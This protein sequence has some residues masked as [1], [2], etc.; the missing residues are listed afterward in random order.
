MIRNRLHIIFA[1]VFA[2]A[3]SV[4]CAHREQLEPEPGSSSTDPYKGMVTFAVGSTSSVVPQTKSALEC[5]PSKV[6][7]GVHQ[8]DSLFIVPSVTDNNDPLPVSEDPQVKGSMVTSSS[9][10][11]F[12]VTATLENGIKY[13]EWMRLSSSDKVTVNGQDVFTTDYYWPKMSMDFFASNYAVFDGTTGFDSMTEVDANPN[14][15]TKSGSAAESCIHFGYDDQGNAMGEFDY[16]LPLTSETNR[17]DAA[18][19]PDYVF[20]IAEDR[21]ENDGVVPLNFAHCFSAVTLNIG[22]KFLNSENRTLKE[23]RINNVKSSGHCSFVR[24]GESIEFTWNTSESELGS[25]VQT[26]DAQIPDG[27]VIN[28]GD[29]TFMLIPHVLSPD[30]QIE[31]VF[32]LHSGELSIDGEYSHSHDWIVTASLSELSS[33]WLPG[34]KYSYT[35]TGEEI[36]CVDVKDEF[37]STEPMVKGNL[38]ITNTGSVPIYVR[39]YIVGWWENSEGIVV[40]PW[41]QNDGQ[42]SGAAWEKPTSNWTISQTD[43]FMY[44]KEPVMPGQ[45]TE[46]L[47]DTY[48]LTS[49][50][51]STDAKLIL[52]VLTQAV[53]HYQVE[54]A[55]PHA[56]TSVGI[57]GFNV[58]NTESYW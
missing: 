20:A 45:E 7:I 2:V 14:W 24:R 36:V 47:F 22:T 50:A 4:S 39:A 40:A 56:T 37:I 16:E 26:I 33:E 5:V 41:T 38:S 8:N 34:K 11:D 58:S 1:L 35:L 31:F 55:W 52:N 3:V 49:V 54:Q 46:K 18:L 43:G 53:L 19:Q 44:F 13:I 9:L 15:V 21:T 30:A 57:K 23:V 32:E 51:P 25:Y 42:W 17:T 28:D 29:M 10:T 48:T 6:F 27:S 12:Y